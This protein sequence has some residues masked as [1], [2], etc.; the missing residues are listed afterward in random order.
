MMG[1]P[2]PPNTHTLVVEGYGP[3]ELG[4]QTEFHSE[5]PTPITQCIYHMGRVPP[6]CDKNAKECWL[7]T[8]H[9]CYISCHVDLGP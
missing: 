7:N 9:K 8:M 6:P 1:K 3:N 2:K 5:F 4:I